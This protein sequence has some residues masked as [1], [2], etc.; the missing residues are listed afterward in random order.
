L[1]IQRGDVVHHVD[2]F[3]GSG[4]GRLVAQV[5]DDGFAISVTCGAVF[6]GWCFC[7]RS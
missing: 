2:P 5:A 7:L 1:S 6:V 4:H 3:Y